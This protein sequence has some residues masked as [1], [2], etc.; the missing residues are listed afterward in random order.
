MDQK[1]SEKI[2]SW[3]LTSGGTNKANFFFGKYKEFALNGKILQESA[4]TN[5]VKKSANLK[6]F[7]YCLQEYSLQ[8]YCTIL[9]QV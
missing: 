2:K 8:E 1:K 3:K 9:G 5:Y 6:C 4:N 7:K